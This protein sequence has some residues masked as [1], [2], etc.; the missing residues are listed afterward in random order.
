MPHAPP[1]PCRYPGCPQLSHERFCL[2]H[3]RQ[4]QRA[5]DAARGTT[6]QRG[7]GWQWQQLRKE[8]LKRDPICRWPGC[9]ERSVH[10]DHIVSKR[11]GGS[12]DPMNLQGLCATHHSEKTCRVDGGFG[13]AA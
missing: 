6:K 13:G 7:Y 9:R 12:E 5:Y 3:A 1:K 11:R 4:T 2:T 8:I 10:V